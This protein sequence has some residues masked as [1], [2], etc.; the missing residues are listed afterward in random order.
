[1]NAGTAR[2]GR[3]KVLE[4]YADW[5]DRIAA[6]AVPDAPPRPKGVERNLVVSMWDIGGSPTAVMRDEIVTDKRNPKINANGPVYVVDGGADRLVWFD[7]Q[8]QK[9]TTVKLPGHNSTL[10]GPLGS[11]VLVPSPYWGQELYW[12]NPGYP[13]SPVMDQKGRVWITTTI[14]APQDQPAFC[15]DGTV[16]KFAKYFPLERGGGEECRY[17]RSSN[18][19]F[20]RARYMFYDTSSPIC[21][22]SR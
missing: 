16:N 22:R 8:E 7:P 19:S 4:M 11:K 12:N 10:S 17:V 15:K 3:K 5:T 14:R 18:E 21:F 13:R 9:E 2:T 6:G 1:M 20:R